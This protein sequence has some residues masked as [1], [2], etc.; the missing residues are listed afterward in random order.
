V[1]ALAPGI[2]PL[3]QICEIRTVAGDALWMS[4][5][6]GD[7]RVALHFTWRPDTEGVLAVLG[8]LEDALAPFGARPHWGKVFLADAAALA[9]RYP[10]HADFAA[11][12]QRLDPRGAFRNEWLETHVLG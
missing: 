10:R 8:D 11:M 5:A 2:R 6:S 12:V 4:T 7:P 9:P 1:R 3:L